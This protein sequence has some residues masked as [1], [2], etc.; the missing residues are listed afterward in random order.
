[1]M[2]GPRWQEAVCF[3]GYAAMYVPWLFVGRTQFIF[4]MLPAVPFMCLGVVAVL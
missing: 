4:Y 3:G 1:M 2:R